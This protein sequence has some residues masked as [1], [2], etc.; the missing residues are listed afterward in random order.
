MNKLLKYRKQIQL[1]LYRFV[2]SRSIKDRLS[3]EWLHREDEQYY[4]GLFDELQELNKEIEVRFAE[5]KNK[6]IINRVLIRSIN[7]N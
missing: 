5:N 3:Y 7:N 4:D 6:D 1:E 2:N